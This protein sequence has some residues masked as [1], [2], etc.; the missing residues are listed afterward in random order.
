VR[1]EKEKHDW[2]NAAYSEFI[3]TKQM[4]W[5]V[6]RWGF[7]AQKKSTILLLHGTGAS[8]HSWRDIA[9]RLAKDHRVISVD[10]PGHAFTGQPALRWM[11]IDGMARAAAE[12]MSVCDIR[13]DYIIGHSAGVAIAVKMVLLNLVAP[14]KI[15]SFNGALLPLENLPGKLFSPIAKMLAL[16]P[17]VPRLFSWQANK[18]A[19][20]NNLLERTGSTLDERGIALYGKLIRDHHHAAGALAMMASWDLNSLKR[21]LP[22]LKTPLVLITGSHDKTIPPSDATRLKALLAQAEIVTMQ[23]LGHL[24]HEEAVEQAYGIIIEHLPSEVIE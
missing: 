23:G 3:Q 5:H 24:A 14:K 16:N 18:P 6:Q 22:L 10:L 21:E 4:R 9:P 1:W 13:P 12:L 19:V 8:S 17:L 11:S 15:F 20:L 2:P 7:T